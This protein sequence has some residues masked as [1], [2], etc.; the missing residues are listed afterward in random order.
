MC[1]DQI[2]M[3]S[4]EYFKTSIEHVFAELQRV[5]FLVLFLLRTL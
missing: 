3:Q 2:D 1:D 4:S 5:D